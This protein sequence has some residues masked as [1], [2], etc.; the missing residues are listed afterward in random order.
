MYHC[1]GQENEGKLS[2]NVCL[3][4]PEVTHH[5]RKKNFDRQS[6]SF[7]ESFLLGIPR[8]PA[9]SGSTPCSALWLIAVRF[10]IHSHIP[11]LGKTEKKGKKEQKKIVSVKW[12]SGDEIGLCAT[13]KGRSRSK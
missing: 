6:G 7:I 9:A 10:T 2:P 13:I 3:M 12:R 5:Q 1:S 4:F 8:A 11:I